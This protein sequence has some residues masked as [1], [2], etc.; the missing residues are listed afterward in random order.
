MWPFVCVSWIL[1][2]ANRLMAAPRQPAIFSIHFD[3]FMVYLRHWSR[4]M[5]I[6]MP[7]CI[8]RKQEVF[9]GVLKAVQCKGTRHT[10]YRGSHSVS[11]HTIDRILYFDYWQWLQGLVSSKRWQCTLVCQSCSN[12]L[13]FLLIETELTIIYFPDFTYCMNS[14]DAWSVRF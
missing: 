4:Y 11:V 5:I 8:P 10:L 2:R 7:L 12:I 6:K 1:W 14:N 13:I 9:T 3:S